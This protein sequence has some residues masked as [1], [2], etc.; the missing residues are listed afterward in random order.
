MP[1]VRRDSKKRK[2]MITLVYCDQ[3]VMGIEGL[4]LKC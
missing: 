4:L 1:V 2:A 3:L